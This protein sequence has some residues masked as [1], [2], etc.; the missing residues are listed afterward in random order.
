M[1]PR[2]RRIAQCL[3][4]GVRIGGAKSA[5]CRIEAKNHKVELVPMKLRPHMWAWVR[6]MLDEHGITIGHFE[7]L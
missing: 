2:I 5:F 6:E 4:C 7:P 3:M 1:K